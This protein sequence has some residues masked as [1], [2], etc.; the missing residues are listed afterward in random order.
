MN[1]LILDISNGSSSLNV[2]QETAIGEVTFSHSFKAF[3]SLISSNFTFF[4]IFGKICN[5]LKFAWNA[6]ECLC[7]VWDMLVK[8]HHSFPAIRGISKLG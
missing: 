8:G 5:K 1:L 7:D 3:K 6:R 2:H 4:H